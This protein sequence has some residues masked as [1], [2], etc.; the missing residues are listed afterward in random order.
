MYVGGWCEGGIACKAILSAAVVARDTVPGFN[1]Q[2]QLSVRQYLVITNMMARYYLTGSRM[3]TT[4][5]LRFLEDNTDN[6]DNN[7]QVATSL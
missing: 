7:S 2:G 1:W 5:C 3:G 4:I 6:R